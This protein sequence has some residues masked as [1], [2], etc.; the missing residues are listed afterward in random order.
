MN[1]ISI[2]NIDSPD[3]WVKQALKNKKSL[4]KIKARKKQDLRMLF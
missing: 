2:Q 1:Y 3:S 4:K